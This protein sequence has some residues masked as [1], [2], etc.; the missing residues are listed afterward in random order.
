MKTRLFLVMLCVFISLVSCTVSQ[1]RAAIT[2]PNGYRETT[3]ADFANY[4]DELSPK[5]LP[6]KII[7]DFNGDG[8]QDVALIAI[9][10]DKTGW[11]LFVFMAGLKDISILNLDTADE[12]PPISVGIEL[13]EPGTF[14]TACGKGYWNCKPDEPPLLALSSPAILYETFESAASIFYWDKKTETFKRI[15]VSD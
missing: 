11:A 15:W 12:K 1:R 7:A 6:S 3:R 10:Q 8:E 14:E 4:V 2:I 5:H 9:K 13:V